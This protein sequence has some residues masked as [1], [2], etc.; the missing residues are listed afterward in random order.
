M[1]SR[2]IGILLLVGASRAARANESCGPLFTVERNVNA[3]VVVYEAVHGADGKLDR[4]K[5]VRVYWLMKAE[6]GRELGLNFFERIRAYGV[7]VAGRPEQGVFA[8]KL[9]AFPGRSV[10]LRERGACA[11]VVTEIDGRSAV[12]GR[13]FVSATRG[14]FPSVAFVDVFGTDPES[15]L[16]VSERIDTGGRTR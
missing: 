1:T 12:L 15:G 14:L 5:P 9:R 10:L 3:N 13:V 11:E 7:E 16:R 8:L 6:G 2:L 4:K